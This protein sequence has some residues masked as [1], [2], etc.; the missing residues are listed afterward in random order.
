MTAEHIAVTYWDKQ[1][2]KGWVCYNGHAY[3]V[4]QGLEDNSVD[5]V[6][7]DPPYGTGANSPPQET[8]WV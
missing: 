6:L 1:E 2:G 3:V 5:F 4:L 8:F 7:T